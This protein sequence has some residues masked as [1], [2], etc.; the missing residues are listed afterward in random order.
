MVLGGGEEGSRPHHLPC[1][2]LAEYRRAANSHW[3]GGARKQLRTVGL[4]MPR[5]ERRERR[6]AEAIAEVGRVGMRSC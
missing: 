2:A 6:P 4:A 1:R 5:G 3:S